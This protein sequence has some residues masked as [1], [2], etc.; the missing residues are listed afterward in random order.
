[1]LH[2]LMPLILIV[3]FCIGALIFAHLISIWQ[4][5]RASSQKKGKSPEPSSQ[6]SALSWMNS[7]KIDFG[8]HIPKDVDDYIQ[9]NPCGMMCGLDPY[10]P[11]IGWALPIPLASW[12]SFAGIGNGDEVGLYWPE[13]SDLGE[14]IILSSSHD[15]GGFIPEAS[16]FQ[17]YLKLF[18]VT[19]NWDLNDG[20][21]TD[22]DNSEEIE[23]IANHFGLKD[24]PPSPGNDTKRR[25]ESILSIDPNSPF[26]LTGLGDLKLEKGDIVEAEALYQNAL[27]HFPAYT[28]AR[29]GLAVLYRRQRRD[30]E[31]FHE[32]L[33]TLCS[34]IS[35]E[36]GSF[37]SDLSLPMKREHVHERALEE[38]RKC[39]NIPDLEPGYDIVMD[40]LPTLN[41]TYHPSKKPEWIPL[42]TLSKKLAENGHYHLAIAFHINTA[43]LAWGS[44]KEFSQARHLREQADLYQAAGDKQ[45]ATYLRTAAKEY[46]KY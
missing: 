34:P 18:C 16:N 35:L 15:V 20:K 30:Q 45:R 44:D 17:L 25:F 26:H 9:N 43:F 42:A 3:A 8:F 39:K 46:E 24:I 29:Y 1:M 7:D 33:H 38:V 41:F 13:G 23:Y 28:A 22:I 11:H 21:D 5:K 37:W 10:E 14:P 32:F 27:Q 2:D 36:G 6:P 19:R 31:A 4:K 40:A 12:I